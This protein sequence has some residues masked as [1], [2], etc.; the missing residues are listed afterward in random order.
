VYRWGNPEA[1]RSNGTQ[2]LFWQHDATWI[3]PGCPGE[4]HLLVFNNG[5]GRGYSSVDEINIS[6]GTIVW[7]YTHQGFSTMM[8]CGATRLQSGNTLICDSDYGNFFEV[9][10]DGT[11]VWQYQAQDDNGKVFKINYIIP[12]ENQVD[13]I[14]SLSWDGIKPNSTIIGSFV[15]RNK[16]PTPLS[17]NITAYPKW[18]T[19]DFSESSGVVVDQINITVTV[20]VPTQ[21]D[22]E[23]E[24]FI[25][26]I[27]NYNQE[28]FD[29]VPIYLRTP[30]M[31]NSE[32]HTEIINSV[33][34]NSFFI[35][36]NFRPLIHLFSRV[37][38][39]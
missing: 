17:W 28:D 29:L 33:F 34:P 3:K 24:G 9:T 19:W 14:G 27:N 39:C 32:K 35:N 30:L 23:F 8:Y 38:A 4:G 36:N 15:L 25:K 10:P 37:K 5:V 11:T 21:E 31:I 2:E 20:V 26:V 12:N 18:G 6:T 13:C 7:N 22:T 16:G 1:Y